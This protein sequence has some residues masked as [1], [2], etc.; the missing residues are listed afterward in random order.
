[1]RKYHDF[2]P[3]IGPFGNRGECQLIFTDVMLTSFTVTFSTF[4]GT[5]QI[6]T[7]IELR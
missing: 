7:S 1:M 2:I 6:K 4:P 5:K 3:M